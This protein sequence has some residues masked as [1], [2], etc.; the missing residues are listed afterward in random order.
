M[1]CERVP[2]IVSLLPEMMRLG[3]LVL[4]SRGPRRLAV[5]RHRVHAGRPSIVHTL[6][7]WTTVFVARVF[8]ARGHARRVFVGTGW[9]QAS[10]RAQRQ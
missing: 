10:P 6:E 4:R 7:V 9:E 2:L 3:R 8:V 5:H 1:Q